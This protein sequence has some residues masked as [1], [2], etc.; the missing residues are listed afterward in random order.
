MSEYPEPLSAIELALSIALGRDG[1]RRGTVIPEP[2]IKAFLEDASEV[3]AWII[4]NNKE[5]N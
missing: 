1:Q 3:L 5:N 2:T 4:A